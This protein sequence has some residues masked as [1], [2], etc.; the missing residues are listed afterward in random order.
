MVKTPQIW[1]GEH[2]DR[3]AAQ[4]KSVRIDRVAD[5]ER[6]GSTAAQTK[7]VRDRPRRKERACGIDR[8]AQKGMGC[9]LSILWCALCLGLLCVILPCFIAFECVC[10]MPCI[11]KG[12]FLRIYVL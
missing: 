3:A 10:V 7:S 4:R 11:L 2:G 1:R 9:P 12:N 6:A 5:K 8:V